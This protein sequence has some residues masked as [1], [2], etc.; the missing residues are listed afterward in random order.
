METLR[1]DEMYYLHLLG[2]METTLSNF[3]V[4]GMRNVKRQ[5]RFPHNVRTHGGSITYN[6]K[7]DQAGM[8]VCSLQALLH[9]RLDIESR[10]TFRVDIFYV[11]SGA[12]VGAR[13]TLRSILKEK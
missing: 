5:G 4:R 8:C 2:S 7:T 11:D 13:G 3:Y 1:P 9:H 10:R 12:L 6:S